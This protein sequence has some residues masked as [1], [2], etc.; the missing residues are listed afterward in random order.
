MIR[1]IAPWRRWAK[2]NGCCFCIVHH[3][4]KL[5]EDRAYKA[6]DVRG[7]SALFGLCDGLLVLTPG[8]ESYEVIIDAKMKRGKPWIK[9]I[10]LGVWDRKGLR[11]GEQLRTVDKLIL[12]AIRN[13]YT[14]LVK[15]VKHV[16]LKESVVERQLAWLE[17]AGFAK[18]NKTSKRWKALTDE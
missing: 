11:G 5:D 6:S 9:T 12:T 14:S 17:K 10:R 16:H 13:G 1:I 2:E 8:K 15:I 3:T 7:T 18:F 4:R